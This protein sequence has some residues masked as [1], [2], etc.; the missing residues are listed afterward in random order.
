MTPADKEELERLRAKTQEAEAGTQAPA[1]SR[2][3]LQNV[4]RTMSLPMRLAAALRG[5]K[6]FFFEPEFEADTRRFKAEQARQPGETP[7]Q[8]AKRLTLRYG[9]REGQEAGKGIPPLRGVYEQASDPLNF[10]GFSGVARAAGT[11]FLTPLLARLAGKSVPAL[12]MRAGKMGAEKVE[13]GIARRAEDVTGQDLAKTFEQ[14]KDP[15]HR[16]KFFPEAAEV[17]GIV[18]QLPSVDIAPAIKAIEESKAAMIGPTGVADPDIERLLP[19]IDSWIDYLKGIDKG[20]D[21]GERAQFFKTKYPAEKVRDLRLVIDKAINWDSPSAPLLSKAL[22]PLRRELENLLRE[23][24]KASGRPEYS[25]A[26]TSWSNK[27]NLQGELEGMLK[28][29]TEAAGESR[30]ARLL[31]TMVKGGPG[32]AAPRRT[33]Q[34]FEKL[35]GREFLAPAREEALAAEFAPR[36]G[37]PLRGNLLEEVVSTGASPLSVMAL[38]GGGLFGKAA[39]GAQPLIPAAALA[40]WLEQMQESEAR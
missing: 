17:E 40:R 27:L 15:A 19:K 32:T 22:K 8:Q 1:P 2:T 36:R 31:A 34:Q 6:E 29:G 35:S 20:A 28:A 14:F 24:A 9:G 7:E 12:E 21:A 33:V 38:Q 11:K 3:P 13:A 4:L 39:T 5:R 25:K 37:A 23:S 26:M 10:L 16:A 30:A 18:K